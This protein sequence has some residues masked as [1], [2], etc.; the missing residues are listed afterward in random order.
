[1]PTLSGT[2]TA[3]TIIQAA[4]TAGSYPT[5]ATVTTHWRLAGIKLDSDASGP[6]EEVDIQSWNVG[7]ST[8]TTIYPTGACG[9]G[10]GGVAEPNVNGANYGDC[11]PL[12]AVRIHSPNWNSGTIRYSIQLSQIG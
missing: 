10:G 5:G 9:V 4:P 11:L 12:E 8:A 7:T 3:D 1:M 6:V 2:I